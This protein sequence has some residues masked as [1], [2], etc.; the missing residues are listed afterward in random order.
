MSLLRHDET[1]AEA[2]DA[3]EHV[4]FAQF[5]SGHSDKE[6]ACVVAG[7]FAPPSVGVVRRRRSS[8]AS[9][10][11]RSRWSPPR[12]DVVVSVAVATTA[13]RGI[14]ALHVEVVCI[15]CV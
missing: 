1:D 8:C 9:T 2:R 14:V 15:R 6:L 7:H 5:T 3:V 10:L 11:G 12:T 4:L 13:A